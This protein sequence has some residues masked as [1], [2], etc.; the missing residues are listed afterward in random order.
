MDTLYDVDQCYIM[1]DVFCQCAT[2]YRYRVSLEWTKI[3]TSDSDCKFMG[4][5]KSLH[6]KNI[7]LTAIVS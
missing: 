6:T 2:R 7:H 5:H 3:Y 1:Y 4:G